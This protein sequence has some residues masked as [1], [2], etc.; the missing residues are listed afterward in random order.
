MAEL[1]FKTEG[2]SKSQKY[3]LLLKQCPAL[4]DKNA[5]WVANCANFCG[6]LKEA[7]GWLWVGIYRKISADYLQLGPFQGPVACTFIHHGKGVCGTAWSENRTILVPNVHEFP[8]HIACSAKSN[9]EIVLPL[10]SNGE[11]WGV[12]DIDSEHLDDF[13]KTDENNLK[14]LVSE[15]SKYL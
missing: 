1:E 9:S 11:I 14:L 13:N 12:L 5:D 3:E 2:Y 6:A 4:L 15:L 7:F 10:Y 8:G